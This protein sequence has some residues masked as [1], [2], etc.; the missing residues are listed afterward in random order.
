MIT[1]SNLFASNLEF[2]IS[3]LNEVKKTANS[4]GKTSKDKAVI[5]KKLDNLALFIKSLK[6]LNQ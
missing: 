2:V 5:N 4:K 3:E 1:E 6:T